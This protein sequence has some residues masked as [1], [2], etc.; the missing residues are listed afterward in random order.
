MDIAMKLMCENADC[1]HYFE[2]M[3]LIEG[4]TE[5]GR[6]HLDGNGTCITFE[7]GRHPAYD[8]GEE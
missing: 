3:C 4:D 7:I 1:K 6:L 5:D 2:C 8:E